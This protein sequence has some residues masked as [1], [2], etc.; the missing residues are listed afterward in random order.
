MELKEWQRQLLSL[1]SEKAV[2][3]EDVYSVMLVLTREEKAKKMIGFLTENKDL[4]A[5]VI[6]EMAGKIA[7]EENA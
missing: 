1:L 2:P 4:T 5:D 6:C 3:K 7:F